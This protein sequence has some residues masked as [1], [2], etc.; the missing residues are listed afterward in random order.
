MH[1]EI[2]INDFRVDF[3]NKTRKAVWSSE[4]RFSDVSRL[5]MM[6]F[7]LSPGAPIN[8]GSRHRLVGA[9]PVRSGPDGDVFRLRSILLRRGENSEIG[10]GRWRL[11]TCKWRGNWNMRTD[12][13]LCGWKQPKQRRH[14]LDRWM[15]RLWSTILTAGWYIFQGAWEDRKQQQYV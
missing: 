9:V 10:R 3:R 4:L 7:Y 14:Y 8:F 11:A 1:R 6:P 12:G 13:S 2:A 15:C 5:Y